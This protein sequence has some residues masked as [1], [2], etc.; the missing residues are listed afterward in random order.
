MPKIHLIPV[1]N[2]N[3]EQ[4]IK[5]VQESFQASFE[6]EFG[7]SEEKILPRQDVL[8]SMNAKGAETFFAV[9]DGQIVGGVTVQI[10]LETQHHHLDLLY[11]DPNEQNKSI[12]Q[13]IWQGIEAHY[14]DTKVWETQTPYFDKRNI[15]FYVNRC[16]FQIV[17]YY[18]AKN[19]DPKFDQVQLE[20]DTPREDSDMFRFEKVMFHPYLNKK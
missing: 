13:Q 9:L 11:V 6:A 4:F 5:G 1:N 19:P 16:G 10:N 15:H 2:S 17:E 3:K 8:D 20:A 18:H 7:P 12:G 14:P